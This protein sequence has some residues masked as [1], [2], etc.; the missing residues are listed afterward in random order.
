[1]LQDQLPEYMVPA[2]FVVL[3]ALPLTPNGKVDRKALPA[4][5]GS[6][7]TDEYVAPRTPT[8][9]IIADLFAATLGVDTV[10][11]YDSFFDLGGHSLLATQLISR[12]RQSFEVEVPLKALFE[13]P[14]IVQLDPVINQL[15]QQ[16]QGL[17]LPPIER[18]APER[19]ETPLSFAQERLWF[20]HQLDGSSATY[21]MPAVLRM[22]G[23]LNLD[24]FE[25]TLHEI[26]RRHEV[27]RTSFENVDGTA[28]QV[29]HPEVS[30]NLEKA[31]LQQLQESERETVLKQQAQ[32][33]AISPFNLE[34]A[35]LIRCCL[36]QLS[37]NEYVFG[38]NMHHIISDGWSTGVLIREVSALY[39]AFCAGDASPLPELEIQYADFAIWQR[40]YLSGAVLEEQLQY[41]VS[42]LQG[43]PELLQLPTDRPRPSVQSYRGA[44]QSFEL[45]QELTQK[46]VALSKQK[47]STVFM[48][49]MSAFV[50][51]LYRYSGQTDVVI[52][53][54]IA[55]R[56]RSEIEGLIGFFVNTLVLRTRLEENPS[57]EDVL[58][59]VRE[60]TL[61]AYEH[62]DVPFEQVVEALQPQRSLSHT[63]L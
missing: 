52:G 23:D 33:F 26:V 15:R 27:F 45:G 49:L 50:T 48:T 62:Q 11:I 46:L 54:P 22:R 47:G 3:D 30:L 38:I 6:S 31:D 20:L 36:W 51:L 12:I 25:R 41:W 61:Q 17:S 18:V 28:V 5:D 10:G 39:P 44:T 24:A 4:P 37:D 2:V 42:Q 53:S 29:I 60:T 16:G 58:A 8:E 59:Q 21:N 7:R 13:S 56:N 1:F 32:Q 9:A 40:Q 43:A 34:S 57:F 35:P 55:N 19:E 63:P 14:R